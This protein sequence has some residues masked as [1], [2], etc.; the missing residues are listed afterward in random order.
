MSFSKDVEAFKKKVLK[1][2]T[3]FK[4]AVGVELATSVI[5]DTPVLTG[6][7]RANWQVTI[8]QPAQ[9]TVDR[10]PSIAINAAKRPSNF[11]ELEDT[12][13]LTN[14]LPYIRGL[15]DGRSKTKAPNGMVRKNVDRIDQILKRQIRNHKK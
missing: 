2:A 12:A 7:A 9:N 5:L 3:S 13:Y 10:T 8:K 15:E 6:R 4:Q 14:N 1:Q 11:G